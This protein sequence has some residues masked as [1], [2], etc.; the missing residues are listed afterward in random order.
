MSTTIKKKDYKA[1]LDYIE[2]YW[3]ELICH[4]PKDR[5]IHLGLPHKFVVP[6]SGIF[7]RDQFYWDSYFTILGLV[8]CNRVDLAKGMV[9]NFTYLFK[10]FHI[11][12]MRNRYYNIG[13]SQ[14]PFLTSMAH[15]VFEA[16]KSHHWLSK[17]MQVAEAELKK[18][19]MNPSLPI[20]AGNREISRRARPIHSSP[21]A[22]HYY[23]S[24]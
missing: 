19:W 3:D 5:F 4:H 17:T 15:E 20:S 22:W 23:W 18:Y 1:C 7:N 14:I 13:S 6:S 9:D 16:G 12:P 8:K 21:L 2:G 10:K 11:V 24:I